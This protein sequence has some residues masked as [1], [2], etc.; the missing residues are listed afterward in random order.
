MD[1]A[2]GVGGCFFCGE[3]FGFVWFFVFGFDVDV[4]IG[5]YGKV[6]VLEV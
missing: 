1:V 5:V 3:M 6:V 4:V 2:A